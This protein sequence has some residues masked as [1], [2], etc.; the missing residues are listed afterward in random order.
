MKMILTKGTMSQSFNLW[1]RIEFITM[2][3]KIWKKWSL[4][5]SPSFFL[6]RYIVLR[7]WFTRQDT[8]FPLKERWNVSVLSPV[9]IW[10]HCNVTRVTSEAF[11]RRPCKKTFATKMNG[12][13]FIIS[14]IQLFSSVMLSRSQNIHH[15]SASKTFPCIV[16]HYH[17]ATVKKCRAPRFHSVKIVYEDE[18]YANSNSNISSLQI[19]TVMLIFV[20]IC[21]DIK[22]FVLLKYGN[23]IVE[24]F[25]WV[26]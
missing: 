7:C 13:V 23:T 15:L 22:Y 19:F 6:V 3:K 9:S 1:G 2:R 4:N 14:A 8:V 24:L 5:S 18:N 20:A 12:R 17:S 10:I 11:W 21:G 16:N 26:K 25:K